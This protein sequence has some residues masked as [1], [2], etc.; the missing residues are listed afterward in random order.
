MIWVFWFNR[1]TYYFQLLKRKR[2]FI[3]K[4]RLAP[5]SFWKS[6]RIRNQEVRE[7]NPIWIQEM[8]LFQR[9]C[10]KFRQKVKEENYITRRFFNIFS[11]ELYIML[12]L[13]KTK[14]LALIK[15]LDIW[16]LKKSSSRKKQDAD[17]YSCLVHEIRKL[18]VHWALFDDGC[19]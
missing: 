10:C 8:Q 13:R 12:L 18:A 3:R 7:E 6:Y 4:T 1:L 17:R 11:E 2:L 15:I 9:C 16:S 5:L 19:R 14:E